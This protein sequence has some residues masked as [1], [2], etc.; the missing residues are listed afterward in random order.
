MKT[1]T[2]SAV[3]ML[4]G[5]AMA[6]DINLLA[7]AKTGGKPLMNALAER[8]SDRKFSDK[9]IPLQTLSDLL[10]A[11]NGI[12]RPDGRRTVPTAMNRQEID[13]YALMPNGAFRYDAASHKLVEITT[14]DIRKS[15]G[16]PGF[17]GTAPLTIISVVNRKHQDMGASPAAT[18]LSA[19]DC[20]FIGQNI[21]L[22]CASEGLNTVYLATLNAQALAK[23]LKLAEGE[24]ALFAQTVGY[25]AP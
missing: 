23:S 3:I 20:G 15:S 21:Y 7:P 16:L 2:L 6:A 5:I 25:P 18:R 11:A 9:A 8:K 12:N 24:E 14:E 1:A 13:L 19:V 4:S 17:S 10:W 22:F